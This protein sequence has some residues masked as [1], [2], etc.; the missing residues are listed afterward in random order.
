[1]MPWKN[2]S[3]V[4]Y[5][6]SNIKNNNVGNWLALFVIMFSTHQRGSDFSSLCFCTDNIT[7]LIWKTNSFHT[8]SWESFNHLDLTISYL[9]PRFSIFITKFLWNDEASRRESKNTIK[10]EFSPSQELLFEKTN[11]ISVSLA[12][13]GNRNLGVKRLWS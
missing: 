11:V 8:H 7:V 3:K 10:F 6:C 1:M 12:I 2:N 4:G 5:L 9:I 13:W